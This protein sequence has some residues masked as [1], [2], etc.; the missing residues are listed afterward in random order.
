MEKD[1]LGKKQHEPGAKL[2]AGK[3]NMDLVLGEFPRALRGV[4]D[5]GTYGANK[6][7][8]KGWTQVP[9]GPSRYLSAMLRHYL[10]YSSGEEC[11]VESGLNHLAHLAWNALAA[12]ELTC[13]QKNQNLKIEAEKTTQTGEVELVLYD[14]S[15]TCYISQKIP[16]T[17]SEIGF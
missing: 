14:P 17:T 13:R 15:K 12:Y 16:L 2:D 3:P 4:G 9:D 8:P 7:T 6:Y 11:D 5:V 10:D 1:P